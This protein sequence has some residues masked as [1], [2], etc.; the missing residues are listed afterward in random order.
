ME[1]LNLND[2]KTVDMY[3]RTHG[4]DSGQL[5]TK[6]IKLIRKA[7]TIKKNKRGREKGY[8]L[9]YYCSAYILTLAVYQTKC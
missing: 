2:L 3:R 6:G 9:N 8:L 4:A 5:V 1:N 7:E